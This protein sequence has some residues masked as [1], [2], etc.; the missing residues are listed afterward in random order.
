MIFKLAKTLFLK[1]VEGDREYLV[2]VARE[3]VGRTGLYENIRIQLHPDDSATMKLIR[4]GLEASFG[5][6]K[7][8]NVDLNPEVERGGIL[9]DTDW[10]S[11]DA[12]ISTQLKNLHDSWVADK[13][14]ASDKESV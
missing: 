12:Q 13:S 5:G 3:I 10:N 6:I 14:A 8:L 4:E 1:E 9:V 2:R 7:N 11:V